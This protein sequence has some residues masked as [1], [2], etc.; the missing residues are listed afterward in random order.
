[1]VDDVAV[2]PVVVEV[3]VEVVVVEPPGDMVIDPVVVEPPVEVV[4]DPVVVEPPVV[5]LIVA[6]AGLMVRK[7][8]FEAPPPTDATTV[9]WTVPGSAMSLASTIAVSCVGDP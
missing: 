5:A 8:M 1:M 2:D 3:P 4:L 6:P 7:A 9:T